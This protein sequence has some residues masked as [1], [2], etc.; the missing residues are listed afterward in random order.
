MKNPWKTTQ[1]DL[2]YK[3]PWI[4]VTEH[5][6]IHPSGEPGI[7]GTVSFRNTAIGIIPI[8]SHDHTWLV[9]QYRYPLGAYSWEI[10][11]GGGGKTIPPLESAKR[12]LKEETGLTAANWELFLSLHLSNSATDEHALVYIARELTMGEASPEPSEDLR[13]ERMPIQKAIEKALSGEITDA[14]SVAALVKLRA[15]QIA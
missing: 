12:E 1:S 6:V 9:G 11:E 2:K 8:D 4:E 10:P 7:Y 5:K 14:I 15:L 13:V 3:N